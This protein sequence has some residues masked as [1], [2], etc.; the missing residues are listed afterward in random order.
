MDSLFAVVEIDGTTGV[1]ILAVFVFVFLVVAALGWLIVRNTTARTSG[2]TPTWRFSAN[3][4]LPVSR[5]ATFDRLAQAVTSRPSLTQ[6][7]QQFV[8]GLANTRKKLATGYRLGLIIAGMGGIGLAFAIYQDYRDDEMI[9]LPVAIIS[10]LSLGGSDQWP[11][12][13][14][15]GR[16]HRP[17]RPGIVGE[18]TA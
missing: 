14:S 8:A 4:P 5:R 12:S 18:H 2:S 7:Q 10:L 17:H 1:V 11:R 9:V 16:S 13:Q 15:N 6:E 3:I